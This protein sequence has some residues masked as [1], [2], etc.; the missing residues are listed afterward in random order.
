MNKQTGHQN[1]GVAAGQQVKEKWSKRHPHLCKGGRTI[2]FMI[3]EL[4]LFFAIYF[5][6]YKQPVAEREDYAEF[7]ILILSG[8]NLLA[9]LILSVL[10]RRILRIPLSLVNEVRAVI[11]GMAGVALLSKILVSYGVISDFT[12]SW[13]S[14]NLVDILACYIAFDT[15]ISIAANELGPVEDQG[16]A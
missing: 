12:K 1:S 8:I 11:Y 4:I 13:G 2:L 9:V 15:L 7:V 5:A 6:S 16:N 14:A 3:L 10:C